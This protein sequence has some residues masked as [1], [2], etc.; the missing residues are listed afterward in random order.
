MGDL[1][2]NFSRFE[3]ACHCGCGFDD[4]SLGLVDALQR[5]RDCVGRPVHVTS[6]CRC[7]NHNRNVGG[8]VNSYHLRGE[9]ADV[10]TKLLTPGELADLAE[11]TIP[12][13]EN[14]GIGRYPGFVHLD[15]GPKR[16]W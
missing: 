7:R 2:E 9:A 10:S 8:A 3:F 16:R 13:F 12:E 6:G 15:V 11:F 4:V 5:L 1:T 14:G